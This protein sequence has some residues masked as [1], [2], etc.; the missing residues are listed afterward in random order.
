MELDRKPV[1]MAPF[2]AAVSCSQ[3]SSL[4]MMPNGPAALSC[5]CALCKAAFLLHGLRWGG[6]DV[7]QLLYQV[8]TSVASWAIPQK[9]CA[10]AGSVWA[11]STLSAETILTSMAATR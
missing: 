1:M 4:A 5:G 3:V 6:D 10:P 11:P 9:S 2:A 7:L 8:Q